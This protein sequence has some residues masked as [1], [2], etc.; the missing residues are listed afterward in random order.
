MNSQWSLNLLQMANIS[1]NTYNLETISKYIISSNLHNNTSLVCIV[2][3][4][5]VIFKGPGRDSEARWK[6]PASL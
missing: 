2:I 4:D 3:S 5:A 1:Y 6:P